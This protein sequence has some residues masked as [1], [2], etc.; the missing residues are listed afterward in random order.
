M[1]TRCLSTT[2]FQLY[3]QLHLH[4]HHHTTS[5]MRFSTTAVFAAV[6]IGAQAFPQDVKPIT[7]ISDGQIQVSF[8]R[9][10]LS[11]RALC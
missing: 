5:N 8:A 3:H 11:I 2:N 9:V 4:K 1:T 7:Q 6:A 10:A